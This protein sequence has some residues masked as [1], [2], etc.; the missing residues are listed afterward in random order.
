MGLRRSAA[1]QR[2][3]E[4]AETIARVRGMLQGY[5]ASGRGQDVHVS[6][7]H[8]LDLLNPRGLWSLDRQRDARAQDVPVPAPGSDPMTGCLPVTAAPDASAGRT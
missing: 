3:L 6:V 1:D 4:N 7:S 8:V 5:A 2:A